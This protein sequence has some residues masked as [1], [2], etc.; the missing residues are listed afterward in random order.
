[1]VFEN[2]FIKAKVEVLSLPLPLQSFQKT[3]DTG[4]V[5]VGE[6]YTI[7]EYL[8]T[9]NH[10][11]ERYSNDGYFIKGFGFNLT[12]ID[13]LRAKLGVFGLELGTNIW[14]LSPAEVQDE[15]KKP[16]WQSEE[17]EVSQ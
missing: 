4:A 3:D 14:I 15:L 16:E 13:E 8:A 2:F 6:Y 17:L 7:P 1:M 5:I 10:T 12:G 11:V 9:F